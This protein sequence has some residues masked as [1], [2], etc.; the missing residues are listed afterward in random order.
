MGQQ[1]L[2]MMG[3]MAGGLMNP[4]SLEG[5]NNPQQM[6]LNYGTPAGN[7]GGGTSFPTGMNAPASSGSANSQTV[8]ELFSQ[9]DYAREIQANQS[10]VIDVFT[11]WCGPCKAIKP[12]FA[13]LPTQYPQ[14]RFFK[15]DLDKNKFLSSTMG[16][17][18]IP[19]FLFLH[20]GQVVKK[21]SGADKNQL[22]NN[23]RWM[24]STYNLTSG[25]GQ[26]I[27]SSN[28]AL[29]HVTTQK[30]KSLKVYTE[31]NTPFYFDTEKWDL[32]I[33]KLKEWAVKKG[34]FTPE[35]EKAI[36]IN[37]PSQEE[38]NKK[39]AIK[40]SL[41]EFPVKDADN[42]IP[43]LDFYRLCLLKEDLTKYSFLTQ[44][45]LI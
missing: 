16:I 10:C 34:Q 13:T 20:K 18:S 15:M 7:A 33:K 3:G 4:T 19:T 28:P 17:S 44:N 29:Q 31:N 30:P 5:E 6:H 39:I 27:G 8:T 1:L 37:F 21:M 42:V 11:E 14:I 35:L 22:M 38:A 12:F 2:K 32:P 40:Y 45:S 26:A 23:I 43:F 36:V 41:E 9:A 25:P 24:V